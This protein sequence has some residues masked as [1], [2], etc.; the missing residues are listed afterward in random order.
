MADQ[1]VRKSQTGEAGN[2]GQFGRLG[3]AEASVA[4][5]GTAGPSAPATAAPGAQIAGHAPQIELRERADGGADAQVTIE[6]SA[7]AHAYGVWRSGSGDPSDLRDE[8]VP[9][10]QVEGVLEQWS[11]DPE[12]FAGR[13]GFPGEVRY[14]SRTGV[15]AMSSDPGQRIE[16]RDVEAALREI[17][18]HLEYHDW[19]Y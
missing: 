3:R 18:A 9:L 19:G 5:S 7:L 2:P 15:F 4:F 14:D 10:D 16:T 17:D 6:R 13:I 8:D 1:I 12:D 11:D